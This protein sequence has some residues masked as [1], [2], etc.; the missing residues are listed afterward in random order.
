MGFTERQTKRKNAMPKQVKKLWKFEL[1]C[2]RMGTLEGI[3]TASQQAVDKLI[4]T[5]V[6]FGEVLGKHSEISETITAEHLTV[7]TDDQDFIKKFDKLECASG[8]NPF[9]YLE[10]DYGR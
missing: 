3:F 2:S 1:N 4:G 6:Y 5:H 10:H 9:D 8:T 7:L